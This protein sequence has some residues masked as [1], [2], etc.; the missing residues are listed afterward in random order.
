MNRFVFVLFA[1]TTLCHL[2]ACT[3]VPSSSQQIPPS[4]DI[5]PKESKMAEATKALGEAYMKQGQYTAALKELLDAEKMIPNDPFLQ[6]DLG[7]VY[8]AKERFDLA[9]KHFLKATLLN[10]DYVPAKNN[11]GAAYLRQKKWDLAIETYKAIS[12]NLLYATPHYPLS[13]LGW[14]YHGKGDPRVAEHYFKLSLKEQPDFINA[15]HGL[16]TLYIDTHQYKEAVKIL[17]K[18]I[19]KHDGNAVA[20]ILYADLAKIYDIFGE[21]KKVRAQW[22]RVLELAP[23]QSDLAEEASRKLE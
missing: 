7:L 23:Q 19:K 8:M 1:L 9:E 12:D 17:E 4:P 6:N 22:K 13:N 3:H 18:G 11:L 21:K 16:A 5:S 2:S 10:P 14:A 15:I 20:A